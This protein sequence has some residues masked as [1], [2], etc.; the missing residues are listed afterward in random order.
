MMKYCRFLIK[1]KG[2]NTCVKLREAP[3]ADLKNIAIIFLRTGNYRG[4]RNKD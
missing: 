3:F 4:I 1:R 2:I